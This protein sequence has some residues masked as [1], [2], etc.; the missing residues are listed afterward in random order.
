MNQLLKTIAILGVS[1][2]L[3]LANSNHKQQS[4]LKNIVKIGQKGSKLLLKTLGSNMKKNL[5]AG[6]PIQAL[7]FCSNEAYNL[8]E[9]VNKQLPRGVR[10]KRVSVKFRNPANAPQADE[11]KVLK[12]LQNLKNNNIILPNHLV[13]KVNGSVYKFYKPLVIKKKVCL[14]CHGDI[15]DTDLK[16]AIADRYPIDKAKHYKMGDLRGAIVVTIDKSKK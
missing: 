4:E 2:T 3:L 5:K 13:E 14:K 12:I 10:V 11:A 16:R 15:T 8:T 9:K 7:D 6:G 1:S